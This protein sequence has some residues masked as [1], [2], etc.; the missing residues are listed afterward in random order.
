MQ[1][2]LKLTNK[3]VKLSVDLDLFLQEEVK[4]SEMTI[5]IM[6]L[7]TRLQ[8]NFLPLLVQTSEKTRSLSQ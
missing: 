2:K 7:V 1:F 8:F 6:P 5:I 3:L 4:T